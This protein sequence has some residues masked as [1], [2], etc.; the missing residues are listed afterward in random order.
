MG[1]GSILG[2][3][4]QAF[5]L[6]FGLLVTAILLSA[7][8]YFAFTIGWWLPILPSLLSLIGSAIIVQLTNGS[9]LEKYR[10]RRTFEL[11][12]EAYPDNSA[13]VHIALK[14][15]KLSESKQNQ[16]LI[17]KWQQELR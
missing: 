14:G 13:S 8:C 11:I 1:W 3:S 12:M 5:S 7:F 9:Q 15:L 16:V 4:R 10:L 6:A 17:E 2:Q